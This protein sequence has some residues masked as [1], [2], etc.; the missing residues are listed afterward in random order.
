[1]RAA[2]PRIV[3][4]DGEAIFT[5][6]EQPAQRESLALA[7]REGTAAAQHQPAPAAQ[8]E[9]AAAPAPKLE[10]NLPAGIAKGPLPIEQDEVTISRETVMRPTATGLIPV[11]K[12]GHRPQ[13]RS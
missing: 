13:D 3:E 8:R 10:P 4:D 12:R 5:T 2:Q 9:A 6:R 7:Q 1:M 11:T